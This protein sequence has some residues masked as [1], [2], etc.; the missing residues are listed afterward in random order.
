M[1]I[2]YNPAKRRRLVDASSALSKPF[3]SPLR[4]SVRRDEET[5]ISVEPSKDQPIEHDNETAKVDTKP[6]HRSA[7][8]SPICKLSSSTTSPVRRRPPTTLSSPLRRTKDPQ[9]IALQKQHSALLLRLTTLR[10]QLDTAQQA[11]K[12]VSSPTDTELESLISKWKAASR[13]AAEEVFRGARDRVNRMGGVGS[14]R[15]RSRRKPQSWD[16]E[17]SEVD[18]VGLSEEQRED[19]EIRKADLE[20]ERQKY[21]PDKIDEAVEKDDDVSHVL[22]Q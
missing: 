13:E 16:E 4:P 20:A 14:W 18:L 11:L 17:E 15:E 21:A 9:F 3:K 10:S 7:P 5:T 22:T 2:S 8:A 19:L 1:S 6:H 12:I